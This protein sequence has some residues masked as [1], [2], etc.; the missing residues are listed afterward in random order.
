MIDSN[1]ELSI[2]FG[3]ELERKC[4][5]NLFKYNKIYFVKE[6]LIKLIYFI[7]K[8]SGKVRTKMKFDD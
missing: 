8:I 6:F 5:Y 4:N 3:S 2:F 1:E 7:V